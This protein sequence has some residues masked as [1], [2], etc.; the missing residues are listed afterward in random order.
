MTQDPCSVTDSHTDHRFSKPMH[1][2]ARYY[3]CHRSSSLSI[4]FTINHIKESITTVNLSK[5]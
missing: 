3:V 1:G 5:S 2:Y 4:N